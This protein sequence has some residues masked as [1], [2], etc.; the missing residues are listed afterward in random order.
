MTTIVIGGG[1]IE[2]TTPAGGR[3]TISGSVQIPRD[4]EGGR[5]VRPLIQIAD[6][7]DAL[8]PALLAA[9]PH[10]SD[11]VP[12]GWPG[13]AFAPAGEL[14]RALGLSGALDMTGIVTSR[15]DGTEDF[16]V[17]LALADGRAEPDADGRAW[18]SREGLPWPEEA[19]GWVTSVNAR[20]RAVRPVRRT[21][22]RGNRRR[23]RPRRSRRPRARGRA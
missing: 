20:A 4:G 6:E 1:G 2:A 14:L 17:R 3:F 18:L 7:N 9:I 8:N 21:P 5:G 10:A 11:S 15:P 12:Q 23:A 22:R 16:R 19:W 13:A